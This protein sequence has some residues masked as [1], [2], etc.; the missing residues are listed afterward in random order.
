[1][2]TLKQYDE[3]IAKY[4]ESLTIKTVPVVSWEFNHILLDHITSSFLDVN[5]INAIALKTKWVKEDWDLSTIL[6][7]EVIIGGFKL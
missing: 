3:A 6:K 2:P 5:K 7:D 4:H 1:M